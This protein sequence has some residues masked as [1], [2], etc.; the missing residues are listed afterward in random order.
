[1]FET[2]NIFDRICGSLGL[3]FRSMHWWGRGRF[4]GMCIDEISP[5]F[6]CACPLKLIEYLS[7]CLQ[8]IEIYLVEFSSRRSDAVMLNQ[9]HKF[10]ISSARML[11]RIGKYWFFLCSAFSNLKTS[12]ITLKEFLSAVVNEITFHF[13][14]LA[15]KRDLIRRNYSL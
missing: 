13:N 8:L 7:E 10:M 1:M 6:H 2:A 5:S 11:L 15:I 14:N 12:R 3:K 9:R 4:Y